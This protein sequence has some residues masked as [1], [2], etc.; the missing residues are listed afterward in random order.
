MICLIIF[1]IP[2]I[3]FAQVDI[4]GYYES[5][6][7]HIQLANKSY[8][9]GY[10]KLR[11]DLESRP[12]D[13]VMIAGNINFQLPYG[14]TEWDFFDFIPVDTVEFDGEEITS[15]PKSFINEVY[16]DNI[17]LRTSFSKFDLT[18]GRQ[19]LSLGTGYAWNPL[20]IFNHKD[21]IDPTYEQ[22]GVNALRIEIPVAANSVLD[23]ILEPD[24]I[25]DM[26]SKM[27]QLKS[28]L[29][30]FD[31]SLNGGSQYHLITDENY[32]YIRDH[33]IFGGGSFVGEFW[34]FGLWGE[35][36]WSLDADINFGEVVFGMDHTFNNGFY[37]MTEYFHNSLGAEKNEV[38]FDHYLYSFSGETHSLMQNYI[39]AMGMYNITDYISAN[40]ISFGNLDDESF[41]LA[42]QLNWDAFE[43]VTVGVWASQSF[44][45]ND[46]EFGIQDLAIRFRIRAYF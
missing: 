41:I 40:L 13:Q 7:D 33:V 20:D 2:V 8:N 32:D 39:F 12:S 16:L 17:Y 15:F 45:E 23:I 21:L 3:V 11:V 19:P 38:T 29:G 42:P 46:T 24:S 31:F 22:P 6:Y 5:E 10:N 9:F 43:D 27:I 18:I 35:T 36:F 4:F 34:E 30:S 37:L 44:G 26:S 14:K 25:W 1:L 28:H